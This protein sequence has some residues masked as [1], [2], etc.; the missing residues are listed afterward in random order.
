MK[1]SDEQ[2]QAAAM[3]WTHLMTGEIHAQSLQSKVV[4]FMASMEII[5]RKKYIQELTVKNEHWAVAFMNNLFELLSD[6]DVSTTLSLNL[7]PQGLLKQALLMSEIADCVFPIGNLEMHFDN[8]GHLI[9][10]EQRYT[11]REILHQEEFMLS[12]I[13]SAVR[14]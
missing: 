8:N 7:Y 13:F 14:L 1:L 10:G 3:Y 11:A 9:V 12:E 6:A 2:R 4:P 5:H